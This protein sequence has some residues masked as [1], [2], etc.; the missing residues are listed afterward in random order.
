MRG[1]CSALCLLVLLLS[2]WRAFA[3]S[4]AIHKGLAPAAEAP[5]RGNAAAWFLC[6]MASLCLQARCIV[7]DLVGLSVERAERQAQ[8]RQRRNA[9]ASSRAVEIGCSR[10]LCRLS[11]DDADS[12]VLLL[13]AGCFFASASPALWR[14]SLLVWLGSEAE[15]GSSPLL[16]VTR[17]AQSAVLCRC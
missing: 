10:V 14:L 12:M 4:S 9:T 15:D 6:S 5:A 16:S 1:R 3:C 2:P 11:D 7:A 13:A 17:C 8:L